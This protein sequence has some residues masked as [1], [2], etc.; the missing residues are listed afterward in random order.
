LNFLGVKYTPLYLV[1]MV[2][3]IHLKYIRGIRMNGLMSILII[4]PL[5]MKNT[6]F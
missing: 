2:Y 4:Q 3:Q 6:M 5:D 1:M